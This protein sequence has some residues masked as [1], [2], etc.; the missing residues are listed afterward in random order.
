MDAQTNEVAISRILVIGLSVA[1]VFRRAMKGQ[2]SRRRR[3]K[4]VDITI[5]SNSRADVVMYELYC[6][7]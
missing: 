1:V 4:Q 7:Q 6:H 2:Y 3:Y 5:D